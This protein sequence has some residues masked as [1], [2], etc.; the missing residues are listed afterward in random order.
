MYFIVKYYFIAG[1]SMASH[2]NE[3]TIQYE[4][5]GITVIKELD[6]KVLSSGAWATIIYKFKQW[7]RAKETYGAD[8]FTI[9]RY[10]KVNDEY[11]QQA[12]FNIS[13]IDQAKKIIAALQ[14]WIDNA[15]SEDAGTASDD[16]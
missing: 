9:R 8:R 11:R 3:L 4:E 1:G 10:R 14:E 13:S 7:E 2:V 5:D 16:E 6:K 12:K 15:G